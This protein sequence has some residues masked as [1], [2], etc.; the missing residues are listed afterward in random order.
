MLSSQK[1]RVELIGIERKD[2]LMSLYSKEVHY[3]ERA[4][5]YGCCIKLLT[6][7]KYV[8][9]RWDENFY[10]MSAYIRSHGRLVVMEEK[11]RPLTV[12]YDPLS[13]TTF[14]INVDYYGWIKSIALAT[15]GDI[16]EDEHGI[17]SVHGACLDLGGQ[18]ICLIAP[19]GTGKTTHTYGL[20]R[21]PDVRI[22]SDDWFFVRLSGDDALA[23]G[24]EKNFY[25][26]ADV[27]QSWDEYK[28]LVENADFDPQGRAILNVRWIIGK[29][30]VVPFATIRKMIL[31]K[32]DAQDA[33]RVT[34]VEPDEALNFLESQDFCN[35]HLLVRDARKTSIRRNFFKELLERVEIHMVN[36]VSP[37]RETNDV[38]KELC[39]AR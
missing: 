2:E 7:L 28:Q 11:D 38:I 20:L 26:P 19:P 36:T 25:T 31:L 37:P 24:S 5:I 21:I 29:G 23:Y 32:R 30:R 22:L 3:E 6:N 33:R 8:K 16:L 17:N 14:L 12:L 34:R 4:D 35:P 18:G 1:Y 10:P 15:A 39:K 27:A 9:E 13:K